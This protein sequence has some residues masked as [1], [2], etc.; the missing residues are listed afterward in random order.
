MLKVKTAI[1]PLSLCVTMV[2]TS[3]CGLIPKRVSANEL[4]ADYTRTATVSGTVSD[5]FKS[6][7]I[8]FS[9]KMFQSTTTKDENNDLLSPLSA[10][11]C[12]ALVNNGA[13]GETRAQLESL[14]GMNTDD[15]NQALYAYTSSLYSEKDC[16]LNIANSIWMKD[17]ALQVKPE[18]LQTNADWFDAQAYAAPFDNSTVTDIN[19]WCHNQTK[20]KIS[21]ILSEIPPMAVMYLINAV[22]FEA[23]WLNEYK[24][25]DVNQGVFHNYDG[26]DSDVTML[27]SKEHCYVMD[28]NSVGFTR[29]YMGNK[30][31][32]MALLPDEGVDIYEYIDSLNGEKW[33]NLWQSWE[34]ACE[35]DEYR[36][37]YARIPE[38][39]YEADMSLKGTLQA[40]GVTDM[41]DMDKADFSGID[42]TQ[43]LYCDT[44]KQKTMIE[45]DRNGTK[46]A[47]ITWAGMKAMSAA[48]A[49][50]LY[51]TLD[52]PFVYAIIDNANNLPIF[53]GA[54]TQ[55]K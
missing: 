44:V 11:L 29:A 37:V 27:Y 9:F 34:D 12:L 46:A 49:E 50:P 48:P 54:V 33:A 31:S 39:S 25:K 2:A 16:R 32:F 53:L 38:F 18:F 17:N 5:E 20:G 14:F 35:N 40:L 47:A 23:K 26:Q 15:L 19:N 3:G 43:P 7:F 4:S 21:K 6:A 24:N 22:D 8:D 52:R 51:I 1:L 36:E 55:I 28:E 13:R 45:L 42:E 30:Y 41:F 10:A